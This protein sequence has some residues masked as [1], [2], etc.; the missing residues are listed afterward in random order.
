MRWLTDVVRQTYDKANE[1]DD[2]AKRLREATRMFW[3]TAT[4]NDRCRP[5]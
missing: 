1:L 2:L 5:Q 3:R 4:N